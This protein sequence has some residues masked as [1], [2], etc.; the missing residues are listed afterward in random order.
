MADGLDFPG[1]SG[2]FGVF[3]RLFRI[4]QDLRRPND[5]GGALDVKGINV[6]RYLGLAS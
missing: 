5:Y 3:V 2:H 6:V 1:F 4:P